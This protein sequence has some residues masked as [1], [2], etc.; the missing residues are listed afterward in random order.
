LTSTAVVEGK[1]VKMLVQNY[2][3]LTLTDMNLVD[4]TDHILYALSNNS[5]TVNINGATN[6]T[7]DKVAFDVCKYASYAAPT[8][9]VN[10]T[11]IIEGKIEVTAEINNNL[12]ISGGLFKAQIQEAWCADG[13][14]PT[15]TTVG[16][17]TYYTVK[18]GKY[19][20]Q[21]GT[22]KYETFA[23]ALAVVQDGEIIEL[24]DVEG[25]E[26]TE[27]NFDRKIAFTIK[28]NAP[29]YALPVVTF[30]NAKVNIEG[31]TILIP[32]LD[33]RQNAT[34]NV[35]SSTVYDAGGN[36]IVKS[37]YN[38]AIN[39][40][41]NST[42]YTMQVTTMGY[43]TVAGTLNATWQT[44]VYGN[45]LITLNNGAKFNTAA[46]QLTGQDYNGRDN[47]DANRVGEPAEIIVNGGAKFV[48]GSVKSSSGADYS[49]NS[50]K[51]INIGTV[52]GKSAV[53]T[54]NGGNVDIY[55]A[56]G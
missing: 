31:S 27:I 49:Y 3:N 56:D 23:A 24:F 50:S 45:G 25:N 47:T 32:E 40:D 18:E 55:M 1:E 52:A 6:I 4:D 30:T 5:G 22:T 28:G 44:N 19:V 17:V 12:N 26:N 15:T 2:A 43:I 13:Y 53:L 38:G 36:S 39:I 16:G 11:G 10:T 14:I 54:L 48:V 21:I 37:Y 8:V 51:G 41:A 9:N 34:I 7:T 20:A 42:V 46:L 29:K 33:A 35:I